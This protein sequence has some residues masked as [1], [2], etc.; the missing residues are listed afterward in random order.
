MLTTDLIINDKEKVSLSDLVLSK[1]NESVLKQLLKEHRY[2]SELEKYN[3]KADNKLLFYGASGCGKT[4]TAK[5]IANSLNKPIFILDLANLVNSRIGETS[6]NLKAVFERAKREKGVLFLDEFDQIG[7]SRSDDEK[8][9]GEMRRLV[10]T[11]IQLFDYFPN[12]AVLICATNHVD[13]I[14]FALQRRFQ[15]KLKYDLPSEAQL[16]VYY[17]LLLS[18]FPKQFKEI[19]RKYAISYAEVKD[20]VQTEMK[21]LIIADI[22]KQ[23]SIS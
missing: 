1:A 7:K 9:V 10:N 16:D 11:M 5:A 2:L 3:L 12:E 15:L 14:D 23:K 4:T 22:E 8:D 6:K 19:R 18:P 17:E 20:Y 21:R 13:F